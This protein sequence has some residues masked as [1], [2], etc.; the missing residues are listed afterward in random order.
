M[1]NTAD[2]GNV[3]STAGT[4]NHFVKAI[5][6][7]I[8]EKN[9]E[10]SSAPSSFINVLLDQMG[11]LNSANFYEMLM[12]KQ[13]AVKSTAKLRRSLVRY[14]NSEE[15]TGILG[16]PALYTFNLGFKIKDLIDYSVK[17]PG[18]ADLYKITINKDSI[19]AM[20]D[21][22]PFTLDN[23]IDV[24]M[25]EVIE[26]DGS[27]NNK[28]FAKYTTGISS[29]NSIISNPF[30]KSIIQVVDGEKY[31]I[32]NLALRQY[33]RNYTEINSLNSSINKYE[34]SVDYPSNLYTFEVM[35]K[36]S[37]SADYVVLHGE[38]DGVQSKDGYNFSLVDK[39]IGT[40]SIKIKFSRNPEMFSPIN[41]SS[42]KIITY[43]TDGSKG[44]FTIHNLSDGTPPIRGVQ[45]NQDTDDIF[46]SAINKIVPIITISGSESS[47][48]RDEMTIDELRDFV[49][50]KSD[51]EVI[52][53][54]ELEEIA[55]S[56]GMRFSKE[57][58][59]II[60]IYYRLSG[61]VK[62]DKNIMDTT[63]GLV[64]FDLDKLQYSYLT[65]SRI[66]SPKNLAKFNY[67]KFKLINID[68]ITPVSSYVN[69]FNKLD[70]DIHDREFFFPYFMRID[71]S[72][73]VDSKVYD[74][75]V[76]D[77]RPMIFEYYNESST[78]EAS[79]DYCSI[80]RD[81]MNDIIYPGD[82]ENVQYT[83]IKGSYSISCNVQ[84]SDLIYD[85]PLDD[86]L[87]KVYI[88]LAGFN[89]SYII[90]DD[91]ITITKIDD[92][93]KIINITAK[94][95]TDCGIDEYD[96]LAITDGSI[97]KFPR[98]VNDDVTYL[99][100]NTIDVSINI[101]FKGTKRSDNIVYDT[102]P[103]SSDIANGFNGISAIYTLK[104]VNLFKNIT[105][106]IKPIIDIKV[107]RGDQ[108][109]YTENVEDYYEET[110]FERD[111]DGSI[112]YE[113]VQLP[114]GESEQFPKILHRRFDT[115]YNSDGEVVYRHKVGDLKYDS[116]GNPVYENVDGTVV[117]EARDFPLVD[118]IY[119]EYSN[120]SKTI[121]AFNVLVNK[122]ES[123]QNLSPTGTSG[124]LGILNTIGSGNYFFIN[125]KTGTEE[126]ID[127]LALSFQ[128]GI[129]LDGEDIDSNLLID[130]VKSSIVS[131]IQLNSTSQ[132]I[133]FMEM[134]SYV[135]ENTYGIR[136]Y[137]LYK[138][139]NYDEGVC[140][141]IYTK[142]NINNFD[143]VT[144]KNAVNVVD[145]V[146]VFTPDIKVTII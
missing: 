27:I 17:I 68:E 122:V 58:F 70:I 110:I 77:I 85:E 42:L 20:I 36:P 4:I 136:Y 32:L 109:K 97:K 69:T 126:L 30:I 104:D 40:K 18:S 137:E 75:S 111:S 145:G 79:I 60:D 91:N 61:I 131:Y 138:V 22:P 55:K 52:T 49:I 38:P 57:R 118:R 71:L 115:V 10:L 34:F 16:K 51:S 117:I 108:L 46:Q 59:D 95:Y 1:A 141:S 5:Q 84:I 102:I 48:G 54:L 99:L 119:S 8:L 29:V 67:N 127:R 53:L 82:I 45:F 90:N 3:K 72:S 47:G 96:R 56:F 105:N 129:K 31:F 135:K 101:S 50:R 19:V 107:T 35:Y 143:I 128:I 88:T 11:A 112:V 37:N 100:D 125:R 64:E 123:F 116:S 65:S 14:L 43:T 76:K 81:P 103:T 92:T 25:R 7:N 139:N 113:T 94:I 124:K 24:F 62:T 74:M 28:F 39:T 21:K 15:F 134:M 73:Y 89:G 133:S 80:I 121:E 13:E 83:F 44:N 6:D 26:P 98:Q 86:E 142:Q 23:D 132:S 63:S 87:I 146:M 120:Y 78:S 12:I 93:N 66:L 114:G 106:I 144:I 130:S 2:I 140:H 9:E 41:G 33:Q